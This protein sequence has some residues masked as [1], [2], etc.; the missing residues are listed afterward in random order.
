MLNQKD[1]KYNERNFSLNNYS[2][3]YNKKSSSSKD[4]IHSNSSDNIEKSDYF[5]INKKMNLIQ[6]KLLSLNDTFSSKPNI[7]N[8]HDN[9]KVKES[10]NNEEDSSKRNFINAKN[11][12]KELNSQ[13]TKMNYCNIIQ[14]NSIQRLDLS[15]SFLSSQISTLN[16]LNKKR[17]DTIQKNLDKLKNQE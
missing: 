1:F 12:L 16:F 5:S 7:I 4:S 15:L 11:V 8:K 13:L 14:T 3:N 10:N 9:K 17:K 6:Q 2:F